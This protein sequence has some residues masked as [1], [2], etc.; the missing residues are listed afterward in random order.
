MKKWTRFIVLAIVLGLVAAALVRAQTSNGYTCVTTSVASAS[1]PVAIMT[2][3]RLTTWTFHTRSGAAV[4][5]LIFPYV[6]N[7]VPAATP[8]PA[9]VMEVA[10]GSYLFDGITC[11]EP[12][13]K[14]ALGQG[15]AAVLASGVTAVTVDACAR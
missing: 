1:S 11:S 7:T 6:G 14:D 8:S 5:A 13:C 2:P 10:A 15:F 9:G 4:S 12:T 3:G